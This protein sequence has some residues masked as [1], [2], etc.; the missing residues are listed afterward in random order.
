MAHLG[1]AS[2]QPHAGHILRVARQRVPGILLLCCAAAGKS[3]S[4][5][6][7]ARMVAL[8][9]LEF[10]GGPPRMGAGSRRFQP[11]AGV[12]GVSSRRRRFRRPGL[13][14]DGLRICPAIS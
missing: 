10:W 14:S 7:Q 6:P 2:L 3:A 1:Q 4:F 13:R 12:G 8:L 5:G 9:D 11:A